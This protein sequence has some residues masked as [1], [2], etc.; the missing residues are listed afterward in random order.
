MWVAETPLRQ[1]PSGFFANDRTSMKHMIE[2]AVA[3][4]TY[5][6]LQGME[7]FVQD[8]TAA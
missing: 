6:S 3:G 2:G 4:V 7:C 1:G 8:P 5:I